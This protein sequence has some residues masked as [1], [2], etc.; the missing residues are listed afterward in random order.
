MRFHRLTMTFA[1]AAISIACA[2]APEE[3]SASA[4]TAIEEASVVTSPLVDVKTQQFTDRPI[5]RFKADAS[6]P[7]MPE[8]LI[9]GHVPG[10]AVAADDTI[11]L[12]QR[13][14]T[15]G[16]SDNGLDQD[17][18]IAV[19]CRAAPHVMQFSQD[20]DYIKG[21]GGPD[22]APA[23]DGVTQWPTVVHGIHIAPDGTVWIGGNGDGDHVVLNYTQE[24]EFIRAYG[25]RTETAG[26]YDQALLGNPADIAVDPTSG[27]V[28]IADGYINKRIIGFDAETNE[29][30]RY[31][32]AYGVS[33]DSKTR[34]G[35][36]D[37]SQASSNADGG[38]NPTSDSFGDIVHC[39]VTG[40]D[41]R[42]Y[43]C[44]RRNNRVQVF[45]TSDEGETVFV[46]N[47]VLAP[48]TGG[49][50][51]ASDV[52]FSPDGEYLY[53]ADMMN[54]QVWILDAETYEELGAIGRNGRYPGEFIWLHSVDV[55]S[56]GN[57]YTSEVNTGRRVQKFV[58][59][60]V[61]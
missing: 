58:M 3:A 21:W 17:P 50:R 49:T 5:P 11:W 6:W 18:P 55:D 61:E 29:F 36:F 44:D 1:V 45:E 8:D 48:E 56:E 34:E 46:E 20:G 7:K 10:V 27:D 37:Q 59:T 24:G 57:L 28:L 60:G 2:E 14:N 51:T 23:V 30:S 32:G 54:G 15:L 47:I 42:I 26:N 25:Q 43:V 31:W 35:Q 52:A 13:P 4:E 12:I 53:I 41:E 9:L 39:I 33:P 40:P 22:I 19:C 16:F 38:A